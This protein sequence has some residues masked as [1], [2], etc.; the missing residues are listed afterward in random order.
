MH[1]LYLA[2]PDF[3]LVITW[4]N[5][6]SNCIFVVSLLVSLSF[7]SSNVCLIFLFQNFFLGFWM[8]CMDLQKV[9]PINWKH[10]QWAIVDMAVVNF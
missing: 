8:F 4:N 3:E 9:S 6:V 7:P 2:M 5:M 10:K 1:V